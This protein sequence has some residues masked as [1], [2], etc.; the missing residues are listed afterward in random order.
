MACIK[1]SEFTN[2]EWWLSK[3]GV[4]FINVYVEWN[5]FLINGEKM[6]KHQSNVW[7]DLSY[8][9]GIIYN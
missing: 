1:N 6:D 5:T 7:N 8:L 3:Y 2:T 9:E 4:Y